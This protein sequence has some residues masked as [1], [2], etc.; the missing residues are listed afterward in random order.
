MT[1]VDL[2]AFNVVSDWSLVKATQNFVML[3]ATDGV[4]ITAPGLDNS[5]D[6]SFQANLQGS[7]G[8]LRGAYMVL[9]PGPVQPQ[10]DLFLQTVPSGL[11]LALDIEPGTF[12]ALGI[13]NTT[14]A[15]QTFLHSVL[16][17]RG[18]AGMVYADTSVYDSLSH[19][20]ILWWRAQDGLQPAGAIMWQSG[21]AS[22][23]GIGLVD[24]DVWL[25]TME[26]WQTMARSVVSDYPIIG[27]AP[28]PNGMWFAAR[29]GG[30]F[31]FGDAG[32]FGNTYTLGLTGLGGAKPLSAPICSIASTSTSNGYWLAAQDGGV[33]NFGD[34][35][36]F[37]NT[38][39]LGLTGLTGA[40]PLAKPVVQILPTPTDKG[41]WLIAADGG[42][43]N[44]G[45]APYFEHPVMP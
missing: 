43:F 37:G 18:V 44:F 25:G 11:I 23:Q 10:V 21:Q 28:T 45:D 4:G 13:A 22:V 1:G 42:L 33:F 41:Y 32:F 39:T 3:R 12:A 24:T 36:F 40:H 35:G 34:A 31:N 15:I 30:L 2:S 19:L 9:E 14:A 8:M 20:G 7:S 16:S 29:D 38:Y 26:D 6:T 17:V 27:A 5:V